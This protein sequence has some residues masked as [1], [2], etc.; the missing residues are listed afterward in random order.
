MFENFTLF[1][2]LRVRKNWPPVVTSEYLYSF[3][4]MAYKFQVGII[5]LKILNPKHGFPDKMIFFK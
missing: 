1:S 5:F 2:I 3:V 4:F